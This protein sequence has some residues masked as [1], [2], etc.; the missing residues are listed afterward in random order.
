MTAAN[1]NL[2]LGVWTFTQ[3]KT[4]K[5]TGKPRVIYLTPAMVDLSRRL[6][7][8]RPTGPLFTTMHHVRVNGELVARG[9]SRNGVRCR[10]RH[11]REKL[12]TL[13]E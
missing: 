1:V 10:F 5:R 11:L 3:H 4:A 6:M 9:F 2:D 13:K 7:A 8:E 12:P